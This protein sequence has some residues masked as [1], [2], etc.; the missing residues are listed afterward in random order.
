MLRHG[1]SRTPEYRAWIEMWRR[2]TRQ[3]KAGF[4]LYGGRGIR[5]QARWKKFENFLAD[6]GKKP[7]VKH[8]LDRKDTNGNYGPKNCHW[9]TAKEQQ[10][11]KRDNRLDHRVPAHPT[12]ARV[13]RGAEHSS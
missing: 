12:A 10:R 4:K 9:A 11:N 2:C 5:V 6:M 1:Q 8:S 13:G 7:T 3:K